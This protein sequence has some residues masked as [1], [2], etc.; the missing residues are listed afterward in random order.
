MT[1]TIDV[2]K[3]LAELETMNVRQLKERYEEVFDEPARSGNRIW[4]L[5]RVA[6]GIQA[7]AYGGLPER[8]RRL[9]LEI[10]NDAD[11][12]LKAPRT[13]PKSSAARILTKQVLPKQP[14]HRLP[15]PGTI[16]TRIYKGREI[17]VQ[18]LSEGFEYEGQRYASLT[19]V[20]KAVTGSHWNGMLFFG[21]DKKADP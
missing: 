20:A 5:K 19:A 16:L 13:L 1:V 15:M 14:D 11:L 6:W 2:E 17:R 3:A 7:R 9:A 8:A 4:L 10:A 12:R 18:V 21:L